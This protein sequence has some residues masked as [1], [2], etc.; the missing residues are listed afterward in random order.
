MILVF[1][2]CNGIGELLLFISTVKSTSVRIYFLIRTGLLQARNNTT[3]I[4][5]SMATI[6]KKMSGGMEKVRLCYNDI[7]IHCSGC[8]HD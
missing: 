3:E 1:L 6:G 2:S 5:P 7:T 4:S 8:I